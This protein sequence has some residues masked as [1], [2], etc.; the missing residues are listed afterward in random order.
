MTGFFTEIKN[1]CGKNLRRSLSCQGNQI[2]REQVT[3]R[4]L[5]M[6]FLYILVVSSTL[7]VTT[8]AQG[9]KEAGKH[10]AWRVFTTGQGA[11]MTCYIVSEPVTKKPSNVRRGEIFLAV[12]HRPGQGVFNE[13]SVRIG[14]PFSEKS[15]PY[16]KIGADNFRFFTG[17]K[18]GQASASWAW[19]ENP[20][21]HD[22]LVNAMKRGS[23]MMFKGTSKRGTLT[24]DTYSL[25]GFSAAYSQLNGLC[26]Q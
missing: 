17:A 16:A 26:P 6:K 10:K 19:M 12:S 2:A 24:T 15:N 14:Y 25:M 5:L 8:S 20:V 23:R 1:C 3:M 13:V 22:Q 11:Q 21:D 18:M 9:L 4:P 7:T